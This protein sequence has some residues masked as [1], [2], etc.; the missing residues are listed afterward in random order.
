MPQSLSELKTV[1]SGLSQS[2][3]DELLSSLEYKETKKPP[4]ITREAETIWNCVIKETWPVSIAEFMTS[5]GLAKFKAKIQILLDFVNPSIVGFSPGERVDLYAE[6]IHCLA[7]YRKA[8]ETRVLRA[9]ENKNINHRAPSITARYL[10]EHFSDIPVA[11]DS[12]FP[13]YHA[14]GLLRCIITVQRAGKPLG[15]A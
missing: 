1:I 8:F 4:K 7:V 14:S 9:N 5:Y 10:I 2:E 6:C 12:C 3:R 11:V 15:G 13:G